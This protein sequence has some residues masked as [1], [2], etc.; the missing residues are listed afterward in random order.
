[1]KARPTEK[2]AGLVVGNSALAADVSPKGRLFQRIK[3]NPPSFNFG[4]CAIRSAGDS[5]FSFCVG[6]TEKEDFELE[7]HV[8]EHTFPRYVA[9]ADLTESIGLRIEAYAPISTD[10]VRDMFLPAI[11]VHVLLENKSDECADCSVCA[12]WNCDETVFGTSPTISLNTDRKSLMS[13]TSSSNRNPRS[14]SFLSFLAARTSGLSLY[15]G[16][17]KLPK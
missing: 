5:G 8:A 14:F 2:N 10:N 15:L 7:W 13:S 4:E 3:F 12:L 9:M 17:F 16:I 6:G 11:V 1:M